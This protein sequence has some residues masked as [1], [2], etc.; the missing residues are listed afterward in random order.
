MNERVEGIREFQ[1]IKVIIPTKDNDSLKKYE[2]Y[3]II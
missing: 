1:V 3:G 2:G